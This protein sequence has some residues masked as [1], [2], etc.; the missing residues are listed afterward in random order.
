MQSDN[1]E[2]FVDRT[3]YLNRQLRSEGVRE[4]CLREGPWKFWCPNGQIA[5]EGEYKDGKKNGFWK[6]WNHNGQLH[7]EGEYRNAKREG[8]W[9]SWFD[10]G[11]LWS[12]GEYKDGIRVGVWKQWEEDGTPQSN[13]L[14]KDGE[15]VTSEAEIILRETTHYCI[16][17]KKIPDSNTKYKLCTFSEE[18]VH[19]YEFIA[20]QS[21]PV[22][23]CYYCQHP[24][25]DSVYQQP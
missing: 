2:S 11:Q 18:H 7:S 10:N 19:D 16:I 23:H 25:R 13:I 24:L 12:E 21:T 3:Y 22:T 4:K 8:I 14:W 20:S 6:F 5:S 15:E 9:K 1:G 17:Y